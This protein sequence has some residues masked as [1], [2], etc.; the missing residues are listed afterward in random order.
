MQNLCLDDLR[1]L[2]HLAR[3]ATF[4]E[5]GQRLGMSTTTVSRRIAALEACVGARLVYRSSSG[6]ALTE[7]GQRL[8][9]N[10][11]ALTSELEVRVRAISGADSHMSGHVKLS[12]VEGL[13]PTVVQAVHSFR[14]Q[15]PHVSFTLDSSHRVVDISCGEADIALRT[16]KPRSEG[17]V[18]RSVGPIHLGVYSSAQSGSTKKTGN[19]TA[20]LARSEAVT[21]GGELRGLKESLWLKKAARTVALE[22][23]TLS[24]LIE[25]VRLG[26]GVGVL[27]D[28]MVAHDPSLRRLG[29]CTGVPRK[30]LWL[31][32]NA[33]AAKV[34]R[35]RGFS[36]HLIDA[37]QQT[38]LLGERQAQ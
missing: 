37:L 26:I 33:A 4:L 11:H 27:P 31:V 36:R 38:Y 18:L 23:E 5:T 2:A 8:V 9:A 14:Q 22:V 6:T 24:A 25:A 12:V 17:V 3:Y 7:A 28:E 20:L 34:P 35:V 1:L 19:M 21:L 29:D 15:H 30:T 16:L 32:M 10:T 13:V